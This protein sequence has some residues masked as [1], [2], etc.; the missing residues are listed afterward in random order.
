MDKRG[1]VIQIGARAGYA[2]RGVIFAIIGMLALLAAAGG[3]NRA[4]GTKG[5]VEASAH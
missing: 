2:A 1:I 5:R 3:R 4:V